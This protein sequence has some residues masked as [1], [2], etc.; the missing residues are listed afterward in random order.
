[1]AGN[2]VNGP[3]SCSGNNPAPADGGK[4][5]IS[6]GPAAHQCADLT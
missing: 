6:K 1:V 5:N 4:P 3:L 2:S